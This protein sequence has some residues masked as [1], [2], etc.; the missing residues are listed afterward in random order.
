MERALR[1]PYQDLVL[2]NNDGSIALRL[3]NAGSTTGT[4]CL[5]GI[6]YPDPGRASAEFVTYRTFTF[7]VTATYPLT[8]GALVILDFME[9][10]ETNDGGPIYDFQRP[11]NAAPIKVQL[12]KQTESRATQSGYAV[13]QGPSP[14]SYLSV[15]GPVFPG[16]VLQSPP[17]KRSSKRLGAQKW[18]CR[19]EWSYIMAAVQP[20]VGLP[21]AWR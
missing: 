7:D 1:I 2:I 16:A 6:N 4:R 10:I 11:A 12:F 8:P 17:V 21:N 20:L 15:P 5:S 9:S 18:E 3:A 13:T 14:T 19:V